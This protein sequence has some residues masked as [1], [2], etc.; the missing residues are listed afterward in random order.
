MRTGRGR[1]APD[2]RGRLRLRQRQAQGGRRTCWARRA[3]PAPAAR[4]RPTSSASCAATCATFDGRRAPRRCWPA[5]R[6]LAL[7]ADAA[8]G[9]ASTR[10][11]SAPCSTAR[12]TEHSNMHLHLFTDSAKDVEIFLLDAGMR[13]RRS[14]KPAPTRGPARW[15]EDLAFRRARGCAAAGLGRAV[16]VVLSVHDTRRDPHRAAATARPIRTLSTRSRRPAAPA[17]VAAR[18]DRRAEARAR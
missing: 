6:A 2:R 9:R 10:T 3:P 11:W 16:G 1:R 14:T 5:L 15:S 13:L 12:A 7:D 17:A 4:Q 18:A 8:A